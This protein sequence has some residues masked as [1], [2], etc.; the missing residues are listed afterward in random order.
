MSKLRLLTMVVLTVAFL[1]SLWAVPVVMAVLAVTVIETLWIKFAL[2][3]V[4]ALWLL[5]LRPWTMF[6]NPRF[7]QFISDMRRALIQIFQT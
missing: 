6:R 2:W 7:G 5:L 4:V 1:L 3:A